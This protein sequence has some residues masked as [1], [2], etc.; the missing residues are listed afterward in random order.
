MFFVSPSILLSLLFEKIPI[1]KLI[2]KS[3]FSNFIKLQ[4]DKS[5]VSIVSFQFP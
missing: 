2:N 1:L 4:W 3:K 5:K